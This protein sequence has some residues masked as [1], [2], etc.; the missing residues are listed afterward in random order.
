LGANIC[1]VGRQDERLSS[2]LEEFTNQ[3][4]IGINGFSCDVRNLEQV[5]QLI[6][7]IHRDI[8]SIDILINSAGVAHPGYIPN[9]DLE[10]FRWMMDTNYF[11][12][13]HTVK[14]VLPEMIARGSGS[15]INI[16][17]L[18]A[19]IGLFGYSAY[20]AS[21]FAVRGFTESLRMEA[22]PHHI[23]VGLVVPPD[24][25]TPQ[26]TYE[27]Q[28]KPLELKYLYP[29]IKAIAPEKVAKSV[30]EGVIHRKY[31]II[32][33]SGVKLILLLHRFA[34]PFSYNVLDWLLTRSIRRIENENRS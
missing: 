28:Y 34:G 26:L 8:G 24:T 17:S 20:G 30:V 22:K 18:A 25:E 12:I 10:V 23:H 7:Q 27:N 21:K 11:G 33:D 31:E 9:L 6:D 32:P 2:A 5:E 29:F 1:I 15:I 13:V 4:R 19:Y 16:G 3:N 14:K